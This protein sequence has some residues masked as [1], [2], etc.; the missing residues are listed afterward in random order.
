MGCQEPAAISRGGWNAPLRKQSPAP[1]GKSAIFL[2]PAPPHPV[3][4]AAGAD[5]LIKLDTG[6]RMKLDTILEYLGRI[7]PLDLAAEWDNVGLLLGDGSIDVSRVLTCLTVTP[8][9]ALEAIE[10]RAGLIV[11]HHPIFFR[12]VK[13]LTAADPQGRMMLELARAGIAVYSAHTA[14]D[15][16]PGG[17]NDL[18]ATRLQLME[19]R[20]LEPQPRPEYKLVVFT[21]DKDLA[22]LSDALFAAGAGHIG[23]YREC[24]FRLPGTGTFF[25]SESTNP[26]VGQKGR[27]EDVSEWRL[28]VVCPAERLGDVLAAMR[29]AHSYEEPAFDVYPL[30]PTSERVGVGRIGKLPRPMPIGE[31]AITLRMLLPAQSVQM[32][33]DREWMVE[34]AALVCGAGGELVS[35]AAAAGAD[36][37]ITGEMRFHDCLTASARGMAVLLPGHFATER[38]G[39]EELA[40]RLNRHLPDLEIWASTREHDPLQA[41]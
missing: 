22:R 29:G 31:L 20:P 40:A 16:A 17:I 25:G 30:K 38:C 3:A 36:V 1:A 11:T 19:I 28:E 4:V 6:H 10:G 35:R 18:L 13:R 8:E 32:V 21:P 9:V 24:S 27:R 12:P 5:T 33:G 14:F 2:L 39:M 37:F 41:I 26:T 34:R 7:A 15:N 23:Q